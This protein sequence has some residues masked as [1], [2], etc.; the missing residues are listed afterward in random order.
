MKAFNSILLC[1][2]L[3][4]IFA[5]N[6]FAGDE[7]TKE[8]CAK[9]G[10]MKCATMGMGNSY[11][12][13]TGNIKS[14][15]ISELKPGTDVVMVEGTVTTVCQSA[16]C[17]VIIKDGDKDLF[18]K[19]KGESFFMPKNAT[20]AMAKAHG[21][22]REIEMSEENQKHFAKEGLSIGEIKGPRKMLMMAANGVELTPKE[23]Q[24]F[25][26]VENYKCEDSDSKDAKGEKKEM[27][28][29]GTK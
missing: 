19:A 25:E 23:G 29:T 3:V 15:K 14:T 27:K 17:W 26:I 22:V 20:G 4:G 9:G 5:F 2:L 6:A 21:I 12:E 1:T 28:E 10:D 7:K 13:K 11:G 24:K 18:V 8:C 16:G